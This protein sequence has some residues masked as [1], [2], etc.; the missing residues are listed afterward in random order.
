M[1][2]IY[3][4]TKHMNS[5][6]PKPCPLILNRKSKIARIRLQIIIVFVL[7]LRQAKSLHEKLVFVLR[8]IGVIGFENMAG[9]IATGRIS[10]LRFTGNDVGGIVRRRILSREI[11]RANRVIPLLVQ[12]VQPVHL[13]NETRD[14]QAMRKL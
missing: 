4:N 9:G 12:P 7:E 11:E 13:S 14:N 3:H 6:L 5:K 1:I 2:E 10:F 8:K